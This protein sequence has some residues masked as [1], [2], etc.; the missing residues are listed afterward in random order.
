M[1]TGDFSNLKDKNGN[2]IPIYD[3]LTQCGAYGNP[4]CSAAQLAG[5]APQRTQFPGNIIPADRINQ[6]AKN[7]LNFPYFAQPTTP[8]RS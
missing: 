4:A 2:V 8:G 5:T 3:P 7:Y 1:Y 6:V